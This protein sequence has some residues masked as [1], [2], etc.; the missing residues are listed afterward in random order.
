MLHIQAA[1]AEEEARRISVR[2]KEA[3][4]AAKRR[5]VVLGANGRIMGEKFKQAANE[6]ATALAPLI[7]E[8]KAGGFCTVRQIQIE[9][10]RRGIPAPK[11]GEWHV[12]TLFFTLRRIKM[13]QIR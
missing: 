3:M 10:N 7:A 4:A 11:G 12:P 8:L 9:L 13:Q 6:R 1:F 2:T 5:G